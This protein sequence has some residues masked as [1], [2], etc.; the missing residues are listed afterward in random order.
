MPEGSIETLYTL[1]PRNWGEPERTYPLSV[2]GIA[3]APIAGPSKPPLRPG[4]AAALPVAVQVPREALPAANSALLFG[5]EAR[6]DAQIRA[7]AE[8]RF[9]APVPPR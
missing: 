5:V 1:K 8:S 3:G 4:D 2:S 7:S 9:L 6:D